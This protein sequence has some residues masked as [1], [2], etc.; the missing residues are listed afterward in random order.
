M[1]VVTIVLRLTPYGILAIMARTVATSDF[2]AIYNMGKF[3][4]ASYVALIIM[5]L[6]HLLI[7]SLSGLNP[8]TYLKKISGNIIIRL[9]FS[10]KCG[11]VTDEY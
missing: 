2:G 4:I 8:F 10:F 9:H 11:C 6:V 7:I 3:V 1:G 5:L